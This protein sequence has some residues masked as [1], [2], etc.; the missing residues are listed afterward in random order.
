MQ[1]SFIVPSDPLGLKILP[2]F[3]L[4]SIWL[5]FDSFWESNYDPFVSFYLWNYILDKK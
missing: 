1:A 4:V 3:R 5:L 2:D